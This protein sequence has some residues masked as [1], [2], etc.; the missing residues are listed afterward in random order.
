[1]SR[2]STRPQT[3]ATVGGALPT[4]LTHQHISQRVNDSAGRP[5]ESSLR[6]LGFFDSSRRFQW[7]VLQS[8]RVIVNVM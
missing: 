4:L 1:M 6:G 5:A 3:G 7:R 2:S 8:E